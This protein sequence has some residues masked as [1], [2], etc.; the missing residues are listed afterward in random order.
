MLYFL[1]VFLITWYLLLC[2]VMPH[3]WQLLCVFAGCWGFAWE[4]D[5]DLQRHGTTDWSSDVRQKSSI[6]LAGFRKDAIWKSFDIVTVF[7]DWLTNVMSSVW[8]R[9]F[10][11]IV[12]CGN[13]C[14]NISLWGLLMSHTTSL[15]GLDVPLSDSVSVLTAIFQVDLG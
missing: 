8:E 3:P 7:F 14:W 9:V 2:H 5:T 15:Q 11:C 4:R 1:Q 6:W 12:K 13:L 10:I